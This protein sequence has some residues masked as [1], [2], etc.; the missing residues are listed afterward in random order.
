MDCGTRL[1]ISYLT[2]NVQYCEENHLCVKTVAVKDAKGK[3]EIEDMKRLVQETLTDYGIQKQNILIF[4]V[5]N[6][7]NM[8]KT[9][10]VLNNDEEEDMEEK[11]DDQN[12]EAEQLGNADSLLEVQI[13]AEN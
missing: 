11:D 2:I 3:H 10:K 6:G 5:D 9:I 4:S 12:L 7:S 8:I 13:D 1:M